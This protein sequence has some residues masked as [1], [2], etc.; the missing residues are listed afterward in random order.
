MTDFLLWLSGAFKWSFGFFDAFGNVIN[1][2]LFIVA[3]SMFFYWCW[4]L[5]AK[6]NGNKDKLYHSTTEEDHEYY[7]E[8]LYKNPNK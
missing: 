8:E 5:V 2:V 3:S 4:V 6:F 1:W 7:T